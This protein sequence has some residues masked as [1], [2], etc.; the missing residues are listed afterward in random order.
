LSEDP[1]GFAS[2]DFNWYRYV[3]NS[4]VNRIDP[5]GLRGGTTQPPPPPPFDPPRPR[6]N[7][8][9][10][11]TICINKCFKS[12]ICKAPKVGKAICAVGCLSLWIACRLGGGE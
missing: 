3:G 2:G 7:C 9:V 4:P 5:L 1:I 6:Q 11:F 12:P 10:L 8:Q